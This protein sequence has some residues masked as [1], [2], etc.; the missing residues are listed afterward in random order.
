MIAKA[1]PGFCVLSLLPMETWM[2]SLHLK[3][4]CSS[5]QQR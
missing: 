2:D 4:T 3:Q 1:I 5:T